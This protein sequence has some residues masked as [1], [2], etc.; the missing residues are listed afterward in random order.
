MCGKEDVSSHEYSSKVT[1]PTC[2]EKGYT[3]YTCNCGHSYTGDEV[4][5]LGHKDENYDHIC[6]NGCDVYQGIHADDSDDQDHVCDYCKGEI[7]NGESCSD[8]TT[9]Q[10]HNCDVCGAAVGGHS[11]GD[12][13]WV[14]TGSDEAG[15]TAATATF[16]CE[17]GDS[18][19]VTDNK[20]DVKTTKATYEADGSIVYTASVNFGGKDYSATQTVVLEKLEKPAGYTVKIVNYTANDA[21]LATVTIGGNAVEYQKKTAV[22]ATLGT[23]GLLTVSC[24]RA[25]VV[26]YTTNDID[27]MEVYAVANDNGSYSFTIDAPVEGMTIAVVH[28]GDLNLSGA[29]DST[30][31]ARLQ[32]Y[33]A[34]MTSKNA[35][36]TALGMLT[37]DVNLKDG[38]NSTD[39]ARIQRNTAGMTSKNAIISWH[40]K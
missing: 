2:T 26:A 11:Y 1:A 27:Y 16:K 34:G 15:Y 22:E 39:V 10:D 25:C 9:D 13:E 35:Q 28:N 8:V 12:P 7:E 19:T 18:Q 31:V 3:T 33:C 29:V 4:T 36:I 21:N 17:C 30:D 24:A 5:E 20:I 14:W 40:Q 37:A 32:R 23:D 38:V 6:D